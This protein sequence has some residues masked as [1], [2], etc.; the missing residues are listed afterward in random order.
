MHTVH[1]RCIALQCVRIVVASWRHQ[2][3][4]ARARTFGMWANTHMYIIIITMKIILTR[5]V[6]IIFYYGY[7]LN[8]LFLFSKYVG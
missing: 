2:A 3:V 8:A 4:R 1:L 6:I 5:L 7:M